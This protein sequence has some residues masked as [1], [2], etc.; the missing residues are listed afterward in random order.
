[1]VEEEDFD[2][3]SLELGS[4]LLDEEALVVLDRSFLVGETLLILSAIKFFFGAVT[5]EEPAEV[6][7]E[8][9]VLEGV[10][11]IIIGLGRVEEAFRER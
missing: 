8:E 9:A 1:M 10:E 3:L 7:V 6:E 2:L 5:V 4:V 11:G